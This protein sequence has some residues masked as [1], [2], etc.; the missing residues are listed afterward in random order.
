MITID[1]PRIAAFLTGWHEIN[2]ERFEDS[3]RNLV[4]DVEAP[5]TAKDRRKYIALD[6]DHS[7]AYLLDKTTGLI[8]HIKA[9]G[10][11]NKRHPLGHIDMILAQKAFPRRF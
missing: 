5:K 10:V 1:D 6:C 8:W 4:Y 2:R 7:G 11:P 9:Y 3:Y